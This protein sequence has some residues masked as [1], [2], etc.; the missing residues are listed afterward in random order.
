MNALVFIG[1]LGISA[2]NSTANHQKFKEASLCTKSTFGTAGKIGYIAYYV[3]LIWSFWLFPWWQP[4]VTF[5]GAIVVGGISAIFFQ[6][7]LVGMVLCP[8][9]IFVFAILSVLS[10]LGII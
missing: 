4:I 10:L 5:I 6:R 8:I 3:T 2:Y 1:A 9:L 7:T